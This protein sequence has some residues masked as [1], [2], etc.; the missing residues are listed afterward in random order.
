M[1]MSFLK[2]LKLFC[3]IRYDDFAIMQSFKCNSDKLKDEHLN[4]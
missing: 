4:M 1:F 3:K 2:N